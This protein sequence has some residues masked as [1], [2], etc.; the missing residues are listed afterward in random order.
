MRVVELSYGYPK[1]KQPV[2]HK[3]SF[4][5]KQGKLN[6]LI[7]PNGAGKTTLFDL[8]AR[9]IRPDEG[10]LDLPPLREILYQ[11][12]NPYFSHGLKGKDIAQFVARISGQRV[13]RDYTAYEDLLLER[14]RAMLRRLWEMKLGLMSVGERKWLITLFSSIIPRKL[15][16]FDEPTSGVDPVARLY[17]LQ[18]MKQLVADGNSVI[19]STHQLHEL[20]GIDAHLIFLHQGM[21]IYEG[22]Y[23]HWLKRTGIENPDQA[24][25]LM[26]EQ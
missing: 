16:I 15:Y 12:Q 14:E 24:F 10:L 11:T 22:D 20:E 25:E 23:H 26:I 3:V 2:L 7:G 6:V 8:M 9:V 18:R 13:V 21:I 19:L 5:I 4:N 17:I 1:S